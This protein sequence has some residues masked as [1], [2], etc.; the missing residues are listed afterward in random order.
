MSKTTFLATGDVFIT[1]RVP[2]KGYEGFDAISRCI[3]S[4]DV[5]FT[6]LEMTFHDRE[7]TPNAVSGGT[8]AMTEPAMLEDVRRFGFNLYTTA[9]NHSCDYSCDGLMATIAHLQERN[10][11]FSGT[12]ATLSDASRPCYLE[13]KGHRVALISVCSTCNPTDVAADPTGSIRGRPGLNPLRFTRLYHLDEA[14]FAAARELVAVSGVNIPR[15][16]S[17][18]NGYA[19][20]LPEGRLTLGNTEFVKDS[21]CYIE[22]I[23]NKKDMARI[24]A[25]I[26]EA[27]RQADVVLVSLHAHECD[28]M[29]TNV[30]SQ[31]VEA[32]CR[33]CIDAGANA[34]LGHGPHE[35]RGIELYKGGVI[36]YSLGNFIFETETVEFQPLD[37]YRNKGFADD[38]KVGQFMD[39][40]SQN[41]TRGYGVQEWIWKSVM[42][43]FTVEDGKLTQIQLY[44]I[45][46]GQ[47]KSRGQKG[48]PRLSSD[49]G[50]LSYLAALSTPYGTTIRIED[51]VG[52][53]DL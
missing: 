12:G 21:R 51:G 20:P 35:L 29:D 25:E 17:A 28:G 30:P 14:H 8:W 27:C 49:E 7:G 43:G 24:E 26:R 44:P 32:F 36:F 41:G 18:R 34:V 10:M 5:A 11:V 6:N 19:N 1:R 23:Y 46:L 52:L 42:A 15:E 13:T 31:F 38:T 47:Q 16:R 45:D 4:H 40:R 37:A 39:A 33:A 22:S 53:I 9:N 2:E 3:R 48:K 50:I